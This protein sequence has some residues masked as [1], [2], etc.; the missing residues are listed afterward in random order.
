[1]PVTPEQLLYTTR[2][3]LTEFEIDAG[4][5]LGEVTLVVAADSALPVLQRLR[6]ADGLRF[7]T[8]IDVCGVD[9]SQFGQTEWDT[10][11][12]ADKALAVAVLM[13]RPLKP[14]CFPAA[15]RRFTICCRWR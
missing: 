8:L 14:A 3:A 7:D 10:D 15:L 11:S 4:L 9:Y 1:M 12:V 2:Q 6:D 5:A 13:P